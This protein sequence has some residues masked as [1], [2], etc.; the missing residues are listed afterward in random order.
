MER[1]DYRRADSMDL[2]ALTETPRWGRS[3]ARRV[4]V[5]V[6]GAYIAPQPLTGQ[7]CSAA[8]AAAP[9]VVTQS[10]HTRWTSV[11]TERR[12]APLPAHRGSQ[13]IAMRSIR[14][15]E[16]HGGGEAAWQAVGVAARVGR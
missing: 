3:A 9:Q 8:R 7:R 11:K 10:G 2:P 4:C 15:S 13:A 12:A 6:A 5:E 16:Y 1:R 14:C